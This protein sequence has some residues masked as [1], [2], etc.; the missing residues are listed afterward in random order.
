MSSKGGLDLVG[1]D[2]SLRR[3]AG[4]SA[5]LAREVLSFCGIP[6]SHAE[7]LA[8]VE[9]LSGAPL[10]AG[11]SVVSELVT[12][13]EGTGALVRTAIGRSRIGGRVIVGLGGAVA[14]AMSPSLVQLLLGRGLE[15]RVL[16]SERAL[17]FV[18]REALALL[19]HTPV[20]SSMWHDEAAGVRVPHIELA[21]WADV[22]L[23]W[24]ATATM[25]GRIATGDCSELV[26]A[27]ALT[28]RAPVLVAPS[29][30]EAMLDAPAVARNLETLEADGFRV[31]ASALTHEVADAPADRRDARGGAPDPASLALMVEALCRAAA[32]HEPRDP[33]S[34]EAFH[35]LVPET[36]HA[37][38]SEAPDAAVLTMLDAHAHGGS[39]WDIGTG[40]G[41]LAIAAAARGF[42]VIATDV[43]DTA[44]ER[45]RGRAGEA[46][47]VWLRDDVTE[48]ALRGAMDVIVDRG[49]L[50]TLAF[51]R[52]DA[53]ASTITERT[54]TG[55]L[56]LVT[57]HTPGDL[58]VR[59][60]PMTA[61][62]IAALFGDRFER[63]AVAA[64]TFSGALD[65]A[66]PCVTVALRRR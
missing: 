45:A 55:S 9:A 14:S 12:L 30:N 13:L 37:W 61:D 25:I 7:I 43:S 52:R 54:R 49:T 21:A 66:P 39:L 47:I 19:T 63:V 51:D 22:M 53:Y 4:D 34:W 5:E 57:T 62:A 24:P 41:A 56:V 44:L 65:P 10:G 15:V 6:R 8:H 42:R 40:H 31:T 29:M 36:E 17:R 23:V 48:S 35:R 18:S 2:G 59:S 46:P 28:T 32:P 26:S 38:V 64:G 1:P 58:R 16:A 33:A 60:H 3:L 27:V 50:H 20:L 11:A